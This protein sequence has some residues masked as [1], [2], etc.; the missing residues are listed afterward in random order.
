MKELSTK[1]QSVKNVSQLIKKKLATCVDTCGECL[2]EF[3]CREAVS[4]EKTWKR[5]VAIL[6]VLDDLWRRPMPTTFV[7]SMEKYVIIIV[8]STFVTA[9]SSPEKAIQL[10]K[11]VS[12][13][14]DRMNL[15]LSLLSKTRAIIGLTTTVDG[16]GVFQLSP[17][18]P[19]PSLPQCC[20]SPLATRPSLPSNAIPTITQGRKRRCDES[21][22]E[23]SDTN[24]Y[25][26]AFATISDTTTIKSTN[27]V[28]HDD[29]SKHFSNV[30][31]DSYGLNWCLK[32]LF[33]WMT[34]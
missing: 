12:S 24:P 11:L 25:S 2:V 34:R 7:K 17:P 6:Y 13:W 33:F 31:Y 5:Q 20:D 10:Q 26:E 27:K 4:T 23:K 29:R 9:A 14:K 15:P 32:L 21:D 18:P 19:P 16:S 22:Q 3:A 1:K 30:T 28:G 8:E